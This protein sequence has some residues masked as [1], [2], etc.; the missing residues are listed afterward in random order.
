MLKLTI[1]RIL[2]KTY[3]LK[4]PTINRIRNSLFLSNSKFILCM[5]KTTILT[6]FTKSDISH[7]LTYLCLILRAISHSFIFIFLR[8][9]LHFLLI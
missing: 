6:K 8:N 5:C 1:Y 4:F 3:F 9:N 7:V 2:T